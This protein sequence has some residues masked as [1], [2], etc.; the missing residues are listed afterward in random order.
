MVNA[1][2]ISYIKT[3]EAQGYK[4]H[5]LHDFLIKKGFSENEVDDAIEYA[6]KK[7]ITTAEQQ[8]GFAN[9]LEHIKRRNSIGVFLLA[10]FTGGIYGAV[11]YAYTVA[12]L[13]EH[14]QHAPSPLLAIVLVFPQ[15]LLIFFLLNLHSYHFLYLLVPLLVLITHL[16]VFTPYTRSLTRLT[17]G[18]SGILLSLL[19]LAPPFGVLATQEELNSRAHYK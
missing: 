4:A 14:Q 13:K 8:E 11:W 10:L 19:I 15:L 1:K 3:E 9:A 18:N 5:Q 16:A 17:G 6:N 7:D 2:L 12:E